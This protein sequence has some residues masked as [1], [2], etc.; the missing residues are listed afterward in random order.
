MNYRKLYQYMKDRKVTNMELCEILN[1]NRSTLYRKIN[2]VDDIDFTCTEM[3]K[4]CLYLH[5]SSD[6]FFMD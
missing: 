4:I 3:R 2:R 6:E 1:I 5:I